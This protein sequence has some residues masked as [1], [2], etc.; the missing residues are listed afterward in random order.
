[1][2]GEKSSW[3]SYNK[4]DFSGLSD[5]KFFVLLLSLREFLKF[6][7]YYKSTPFRILSFLKILGSAKDS[8]F[9]V[10]KV[11]NVAAVLN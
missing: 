10:V 4:E 2:I 11:L 6:M 9:D 3:K 7:H 8:I 5:K 1:M